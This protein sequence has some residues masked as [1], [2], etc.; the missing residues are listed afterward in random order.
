MRK[1]SKNPSPLGAPCTRRTMSNPDPTM[2]VEQVGN[3]LKVRTV[4][5]RSMP[6]RRGAAPAASTGKKNVIYNKGCSRRLRQAVRGVVDPWSFLTI[7]FPAWLAGDEDFVK[8][9]WD[10]VRRWLLSKQA[11][12]VMVLEFTTAG[13]PHF[14]VVVDV[15]ISGRELEVE[16]ARILGTDVA[17]VRSFGVRAS[18]VHSPKNL[19][20]YMA[21]AWQKVAPAGW[22]VARWWSSF[23]KKKPT[24]PK[25]VVRGLLSTM[26][27]FLWHLWNQR[28]GGK[29]PR[30][31]SGNLPG[32]FWVTGGVDANWALLK[33][34]GLVE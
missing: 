15:P 3:D 21:K 5:P 11:S 26:S 33:G 23:G 20:K 7:T 28:P 12:G 32:R 2:V 17:A 6:S 9:C 1:P 31:P 24:K 4:T 16:W 8:R 25:L 34:L 14:H 13:T 30:T 10:R 22:S 19:V 27:T 18:H 29:P